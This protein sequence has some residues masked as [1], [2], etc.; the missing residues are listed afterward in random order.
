MSNSS[1]LKVMALIISGI[2]INKLSELFAISAPLI[3][4]L[5]LVS[6]L[7]LLAVESPE[8]VGARYAKHSGPAADLAKFSLASLLL[9]ACI[10]A[11][12]VI[13]LFRTRSL[14]MPWGATDYFVHNY[15]VAAASV[16]TLLACIPAARRR[17]PVQWM[18]FLTSAM[19]GMS[20][21][22]VSLK[23]SRWEGEIYVP[24][25][26]FLWTFLG[27][28]VFSVTVTLIVALGRDI[29]RLFVAFWG[30]DVAPR[31]STGNGESV[32]NPQAVGGDKDDDVSL[33]GQSTSPLQRPSRS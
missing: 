13:P 24:G 21:A 12:S 30:P 31:I 19:T 33:D 25:N 18:A 7:L 20:L 11:I 8:V 17:K 4:L 29:G 32:S 10:G 2:A 27:W 28:L 1:L 23:P 6:L 9:G 22:V 5:A 16:I 3:I 14:S 26:S 15:E